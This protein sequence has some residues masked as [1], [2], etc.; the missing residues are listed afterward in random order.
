LSRLPL[1]QVLRVP[2]PIDENGNRIFDAREEMELHH[3]I[4]EEQKDTTAV[5]ASFEPL[6]KGAVAIQQQRQPQP[7]P[8]ETAAKPPSP[9][10]FA[11]KLDKMDIHASTL[12]VDDE[13]DA[14]LGLGVTAAA[15]PK[16]PAVLSISGK[17]SKAGEEGSL[18][19]WLDN[20]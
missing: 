8:A 17:D 7:V 6:E 9:V 10:E 4:I 14:L 15:P 2:P 19:A 5:K 18:Q 3:T 12:D 11:D 20:L 13:L 1:H 16:H